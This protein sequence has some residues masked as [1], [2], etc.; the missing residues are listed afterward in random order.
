MN[1]LDHGENDVPVMVGQEEQGKNGEKK[2]DGPDPVND[3]FENAQQQS[4]LGSHGC[5]RCGW[6][7]RQRFLCREVSPRRRGSDQIFLTIQ[8]TA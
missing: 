5:P 4:W 3:G 1:S 6:M 7:Q 8:K 2:E